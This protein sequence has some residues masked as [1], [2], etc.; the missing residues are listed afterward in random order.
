[1]LYDND[2][3]GKKNESPYGLI[4]YRNP[5]VYECQPQIHGIAGDLVRAGD[6]EATWRTVGS[7]CC[8]DALKP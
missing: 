6:D 2:Y 7:N 8:A 5:K 4:R 1:M 3:D